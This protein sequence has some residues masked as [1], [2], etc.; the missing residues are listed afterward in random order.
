MGMCF[1]PTPRQLTFTIIDASPL[2]LRR[3]PLRL[4]RSK[5]QLTSLVCQHRTAEKAHPCSGHR[6][7]PRLPKEEVRLRLLA[8]RSTLDSK[9][10]PAASDS[11]VP[12]VRRLQYRLHSRHHHT[13]RKSCKEK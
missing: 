11:T 7:C 12:H 13:G 8:L 9:I 4:R 6:V 10:L 3:G 2:R 1:P 5:P